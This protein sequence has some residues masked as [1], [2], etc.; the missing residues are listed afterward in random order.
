MNAAIDR[1][2]VPLRM[3]CG[4]GKRQGK[5]ARAKLFTALV[6][7]GLLCSNP[8]R[9][10]LIDPA[11]ASASYFSITERSLVAADAASRFRS[12]RGTGCSTAEAAAP[13]GLAAPGC[14]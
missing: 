14:A 8:L 1:T 7:G 12:P 6:R 11:L 10:A 2:K 9:L 5:R 3:E 4:L 13:F